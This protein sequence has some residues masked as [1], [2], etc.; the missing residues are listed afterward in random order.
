MT[1]P[2][3]FI[4]AL[5]PKQNKVHTSSYKQKCYIYFSLHAGKLMKACEQ[6]YK[7]KIGSTLENEYYLI[8][9]DYNLLIA[10]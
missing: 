6:S 9:H 3:M 8:C 10:V 1:Y 5:C 7:V 4:A 2:C